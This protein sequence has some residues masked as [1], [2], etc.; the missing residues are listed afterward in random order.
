MGFDEVDMNQ[1]TRDIHG[2]FSRSNGA[3][4]SS[5]FFFA[6]SNVTL[7]LYNVHSIPLAGCN[8]KSNKSWV[9]FRILFLHFRKS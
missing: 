4:N 7:N 5:F 3:I 1:N 6:A 9:M 8:V 2:N